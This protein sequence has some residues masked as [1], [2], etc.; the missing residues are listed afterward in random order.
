MSDE[1]FQIVKTELRG[2]VRRLTAGAKPGPD[3]VSG[4]CISQDGIV[5][6]FKDG[7]GPYLKNVNVILIFW[8]HEWTTGNAVPSAEQIV[9]RI[10]ALL[11]TSFLTGL[12]QYHGIRKATVRAT[13]IHGTH[14]PHLFGA[15]DLADMVL[16]QI[17][18]GHVP[19]FGTEDAV[20]FAITPAGVLSDQPPDVGF[21][22]PFLA[23]GGGPITQPT[24]L[25]LAWVG[26]DGT[27]DDGNSAVKVFSHELVESCSDP[28]NGSGISVTD[29]CGNFSEIGDVCNGTLVEIDGSKINTYWSEHDKKCILPRVWSV[30]WFFSVAKKNPAAGLRHSLP[31]P[32]LNVTV[33]DLLY[34]IL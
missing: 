15:G 12:A 22:F 1:Q 2:R 32:Q 30:R 20:Y 5:Q 10:N 16:N 24:L 25:R 14:V 7:G 34:Q 3:P 27:L 31:F 21:H 9:N 18:G 19:F 33:K 11:D 26:N 6:A 4:D 28:N 13:H 17:V 23:M 29:S 8:G